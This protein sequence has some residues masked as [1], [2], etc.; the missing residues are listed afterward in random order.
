M[1]VAVAVRLGV[2]A[3]PLGAG[4]ASREEEEARPVE[5]MMSRKEEAWS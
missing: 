3:P 2:V 1:A 5:W 4:I